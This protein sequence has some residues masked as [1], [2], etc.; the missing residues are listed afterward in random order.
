MN[1]PKL[2]FKEFNKEWKKEKFKQ[3]SYYSGKRNKNNLSLIP[4]AITNIN[5][6]VPQNEAHNEF[7]YMKNTNR[8]A[9]NIVTPK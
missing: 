6:F 1:V 2:R 8:E 3:F 5:G 7:G 4:Y 9:Y